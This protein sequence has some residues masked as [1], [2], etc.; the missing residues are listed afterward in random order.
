M[1]PV[2]YFHSVAPVINQKWTRKFLTL[3]LKYFE[4]FLEYLKKNNWET[5]LLEEYSNFKLQKNVKSIDKKIVLTFD[6]G[7]VDNFI[8]AYPLLKKY[9]MKATLF[10]NPEFID[11]KNGIRKNLNDYWSN[12]ISYSDLLQWGYISWEEAKIMENEKVFD[13]QSHT[14]THDKYFVS[15]NLTR[16]HSPGNDCLYPIGNL[17]PSKKPYYI[18][19]SEFES[20]LPYGY[21][22]FEEKSAVI[23]K[24]VELNPE[25]INEIVRNTANK[26]F[27]I[28]EEYQKVFHE[29]AKTIEKYRANSNSIIAIESQSEYEKRVEKELKESKEIIEKKLNKKVDYC[30]WPHGDN[31]EFVHSKAL[32]IGYKATSLGKMSKTSLDDTRFDRIGIGKS[33]NSLLLTKLK[34][35]YKVKSYQEK[36]PYKLINTIYSKIQNIT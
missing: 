12:K 36:Q 27:H 23:A 6:D 10:I 9:N 14:L 29:A 33:K 28:N 18:T 22:F 1:I 24:K 17:Y 31:N 21:P 7:F 2:V 4:S 16:L 19:D 8:Y 25:M 35:I 34:Y 5:I 15:D 3:E 11:E 30:C 32:E 20:N 13:I 26:N